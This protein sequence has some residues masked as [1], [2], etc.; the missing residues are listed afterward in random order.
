LEER[1]CLTTESVEG[2]ALAFQSIDDV[3]GCDGLSLGVLSVCDGI[4]DDTFEEGLEDQASL[5][6][7]DWMEVS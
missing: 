7:D 2:A 4:A 5:F 3:E 1:G 6:V